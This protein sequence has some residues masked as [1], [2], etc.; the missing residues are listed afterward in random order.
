MALG[1]CALGVI[2]FVMLQLPNHHVS[3]AGDDVTASGGIQIGATYVNTSMPANDCSGCHDVN[4]AGWSA[5][6]HA[7]AWP[8]LM[9]STLDNASRQYCEPCHATGAGKPSFYPSTGYNTTTNGPEYLQNVTCQ[10]CHGPASNH[11]SAPFSGKQENISMLLNAS[12]CGECHNAG[13][14]ISS[15][16]H[17]TYDEWA[18][19]GH[20]SA[21]TLPSYIKSNANCSG[22]HDAWN[23][24][25]NIETGVLR[26]EFRLPGEDA[27]LTFEISCAVCH[28]PHSLGSANTQ[29]RLPAEQICQK[30]HT[31]EDA[32]PGQAVHHPQAQVRDNTAGYLVD[33]TGLDYMDGMAC[34]KCH[35]AENNAGLP[36]HTFAPNPY[37]C[38][39]CHGAGTFPTNSSA[40][41]YIDT[42]E[43]M[44]N[45]GINGAQPVVDQSY[46]LIIQMGGNRTAQDLDGLMSEYEIA[47]FNLETVISDGSYGNHNPGLASALLN[48][49]LARASGIVTSLTPPDKIMGIKAVWLPNGSLS[50]TWNVS[51]A[52]DFASY[53]IY[54][55]TTDV[56]NITASSPLATVANISISNLELTGVSDDTAVY[57]YVTAI[58]TDGNEITNSVTASIVTGNLDQIIQDLQDQLADLEDQVNDLE[59]Q[60]NELTDDVAGLEDEVSDLKSQR[61]SMSIVALAVGIVVGVILGMLLGRKRAPKEKPAEEPKT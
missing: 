55:L 54:V 58:D 57:V 3:D 27:A 38:V 24:I 42:V 53:R 32:A 5:T 30:C 25:Q 13:G 51:E 19:S 12:L 15:N 33:R 48:D 50:V 28:D 14:N 9:N 47:D 4:Y 2:V 61:L 52:S 16:H 34:S 26:T 43:R 7:W 39:A 45:V 46:E 35:M 59:N 22:C 18:L 29:L 6:K 20:N 1:L 44:T 49:A 10:T 40:Q 17:P 21:A 56:T 23:A 8:T 36:N 37:S 60:N 31:Q 41:A 11:I